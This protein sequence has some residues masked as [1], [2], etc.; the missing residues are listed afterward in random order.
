MSRLRGTAA[1]V[2]STIV[3]LLAF[4]APMLAQGST[5]GE[6]H[7]RVT[8]QTGGGVVGALVALENAAAQ[9]WTVTT[10]REGRYTFGRLPP[11]PYTLTVNAQ[12]FL[13]FADPIE[14]RAEGA[15]AD[16]ALSGISFV[17]VFGRQG[18]RRIPAGICRLL[19]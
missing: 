8:D 12:G 2:R 1:T 17:E 19:L 4:A 11:G 15:T 14:V 3:M 6:L 7:G 18:C 16:I 9:R 10:D 5:S 13:E